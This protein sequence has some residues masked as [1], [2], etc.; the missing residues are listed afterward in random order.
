MQFGACDRDIT[1]LR[2]ILPTEKDAATNAGQA[3]LRGSRN[4]TKVTG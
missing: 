1:W 2:N 3:V 4:I